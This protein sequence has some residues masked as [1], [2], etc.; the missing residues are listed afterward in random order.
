MDDMSTE[1]NYISCNPK[2]SKAV[3]QEGNKC[4]FPKKVKLWLAGKQSP[5]YVLDFSCSGPPKVPFWTK[6]ECPALSRFR[7]LRWA[8]CSG[9]E[10]HLSLPR[11]VPITNQDKISPK[12][13]LYLISAKRLRSDPKFKG[14]QNSYLCTEQWGERLQVG[15]RM[16]LKQTHWKV[17]T[18]AWM[19]TPSGLCIQS[20]LP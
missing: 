18:P 17:C 3:N 4:Y 6:R 16:T 9:D 8:N 13:T 19:V 12:L 20:S 1:S 5:C 2:S 11:M 7:I 15:L 14:N 10:H